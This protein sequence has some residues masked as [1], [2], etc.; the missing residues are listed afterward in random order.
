MTLV[1]HPAADLFPMLSDSELRALADDIKANGQAI[2]VA[3][4]NGTYILD[5]RNRCAACKLA[6][7]EPITKETLDEVWDSFADGD[8]ED[9]LRDAVS[10]IRG[11]QVETGFACPLSRH[12]EAKSVGAK[13]PDGSWVGWTYW[14]GGGKHSHPQEIEWMPEAYDLTCAEEQK[15]VT[16]QTFAKVS[17]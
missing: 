17:A 9:T 4:L 10:D 13:L 3:V 6:G 16:V 7:V 8:C 2:P 5:G 14:Y 15:L 1:P 11:G 12:F